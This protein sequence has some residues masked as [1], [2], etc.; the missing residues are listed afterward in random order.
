MDEQAKNHSHSAFRLSPAV[1]RDALRG[2]TRLPAV[3]APREDLLRSPAALRVAELAVDS[4]IGLYNYESRVELEW[5]ESWIPMDRPDLGVDG[6][7]PEW[8]RGVLPEP[9]YSA[10]RHDLLTGSLHA[11][12]RAKWTAHELC[13]GLV[14]FAWHEEASSLYMAVAA[15]LAE[16]VPVALWYFW[17]EAWLKRCPRHAHQRVAGPAWCPDCEVAARETFVH[18]DSHAERWLREGMDFVEREVAASLA[19]IRSGRPVFTPWAHIDLMSDGLAYA[20]AHAAR[21]RSPEFQSWIARFGSVH[22]ERG[23]WFEDLERFAARVLAVARAIVNS[24]EL[25][26]WVFGKQPAALKASDVAGRLL[27]VGADTDG[28]CW[29]ELDGLVVGLAAAYTKGD[30]AGIEAALGECAAGYAELHAEYELPEAEEVFAIGQRISPEFGFGIAQIRAGLETACARTL[31]LL[32]DEADAVVAAFATGDEP[33]RAFLGRRFAAFLGAGKAGEVATALADVATLE[34]AIAHAA[35][36]D[37]VEL[38]LG[39]DGASPDGL[40]LAYGV[41]L[42]SATRDVAA[43]VMHE[44]PPEEAK[45]GVFAW[46]VRRDAADQVGLTAL[47]TTTAAA[48]RAGFEVE[49]DALDAQAQYELNLLAEEAFVV[50]D[51]WDIKLPHEAKAPSH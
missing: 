40:K 14:G 50:P 44:V 22:G 19:T 1:Y 38:S 39:W 4:G 12:Q 16:V 33:S 30:S 28:D 46:L 34:A 20:S 23:G 26:P 13:H 8:H 29:V 37:V 7:P 45:K 36:P 21:L 48:I 49:G 2:G 6:L 42:V 32:G 5:P 10:F 3:G 17:D 25:M 41:E 18:D 27:H 35:P 9:K 24:D 15:R 47:S 31:A 11:G 51:R 43:I